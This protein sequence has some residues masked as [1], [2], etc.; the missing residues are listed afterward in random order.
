MK[1]RLSFYLAASVIVAV[2]STQSGGE[3]RPKAA[4]FA[5]API[6]TLSTDR[7]S[8]ICDVYTRFYCKDATVTLTNTGNAA[9]DISRIGIEWGP[10]LFSET[11][12]CG[13]VLLPGKS[14]TIYL[15]WKGTNGIGTL[16]ILDNS[17]SGHQAVLLFG[18][19]W[20]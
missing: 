8:F 17:G 10:S 13:T 5:A 11:N 2:L 19:T 15:Y 20:P 16:G 3:V 12:N 4:S 7:I 18:E 6:A 14:C 1:V 9:L